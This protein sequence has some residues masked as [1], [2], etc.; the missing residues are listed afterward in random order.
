MSQPEARAWWAEVE[1]LRETIE[2]RRAG[3]DRFVSSPAAVAPVDVHPRPITHLA[4]AVARP[5]ARR[6]VRISGH[7]G[8]PPQPRPLAVARVRQPRALQT[9]GQRPDRIAGW[10]ALLGLVLVLVSTITH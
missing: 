5:Q 10:A 7:V 8:E 9:A 4:P 3:Q 6:T 2:R 1:D